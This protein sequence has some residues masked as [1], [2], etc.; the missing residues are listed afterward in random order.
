MS[1]E[2]K[3]LLREQA[4]DDYFKYDCPDVA[5]IREWP[6]EKECTCGFRGVPDRTD[7]KNGYFLSCPDCGNVAN[8]KEIE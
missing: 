2:T 6:R 7:G 3:E 8:L 5:I 1:L 4:R